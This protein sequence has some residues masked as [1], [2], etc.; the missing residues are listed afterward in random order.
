M[1]I[2]SVYFPPGHPLWSYETLS[3]GKHCLE[4]RKEVYTAVTGKHF[5]V[6]PQVLRLLIQ[7]IPV[8]LYLN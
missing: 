1:D 7:R 2:R 3:L 4:Q 6:K 8:W 5:F